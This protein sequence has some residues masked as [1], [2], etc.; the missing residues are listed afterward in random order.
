MQLYHFYH[1]TLARRLF[2][3]EL[4]RFDL[5]VW[6][7]V[8][9]QSLVGVFIP[10]FLLQ[11]D[12]T[13]AEVMRFYLLA[14]AL[15]V[16]LNLVGRWLVQRI[17]AMRTIAVGL[18]SQVLFFALLYGLT[19]NSWPMLFA[20][21]LVAALADVCYWIAHLYFFIRVSPNDENVS[22]DTSMLEITRHIGGLFAPA[23]GAGILLLATQQTLIALSA[24]IIALSIVPILTIRGIA[25]KPTSPPMP[26]RTF[27]TCWDDARDYVVR[28]LHSIHAAAE[29]IVWPL[30]IYFTFAT[31][32]SVAAVP[33]ILAVTTIIF[34]FFVGRIRKEYRTHAITIGALLTACMWTLRPSLTRRSSSTGASSSS[35]SSP[36]SSPFPWTATSLRQ[37]SARTRSAHP[38]TATRSACSRGSSSSASSSSSPRSST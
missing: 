31:I 5:A 21:A 1:S 28:S 6:L 22:Q 20:L 19:P 15:N 37:V 16:P 33:I 2:R 26:L 11:L 3:S 29:G 4:G 23:I 13:L 25:D 18:A 8:F 9:G 32:A 35:V 12:Y 17:G 7:N 38:R 34:T 36:C 14:M 10:I 27:F 24:I 30:F